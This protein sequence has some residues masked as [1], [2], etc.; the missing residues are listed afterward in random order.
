MDAYN[1]MPEFLKELFKPAT[2]AVTDLVE[3]ARKENK[4]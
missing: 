3:S 1:K 4:Q 2:D